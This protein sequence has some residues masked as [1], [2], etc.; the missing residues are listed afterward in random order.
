MMAVV[1][2]ND[3]FLCLQRLLKSDKAL[4]ISSKFSAPSWPAISDLLL[5]LNSIGIQVKKVV[6]LALKLSLQA[7]RGMA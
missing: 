3:S 6:Y 5:L 4:S 1:R 2:N 7:T